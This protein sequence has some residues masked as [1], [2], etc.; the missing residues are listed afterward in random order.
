MFIKRCYKN[1]ELSFLGA[2]LRNWLKRLRPHRICGYETIPEVYRFG[3][4]T[5]TC[6]EMYEQDGSYRLVPRT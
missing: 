2:L 1:Y 6:N 4:L 5:H 3:D